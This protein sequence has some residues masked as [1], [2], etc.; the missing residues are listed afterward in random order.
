MRIPVSFEHLRLPRVSYG[1]LGI[2]DARLLGVSFCVYMWL[3]AGG[4]PIGNAGYP[5]VT[6][7]IY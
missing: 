2:P 3:P 7:T 5:P 1:I 4:T 6:K